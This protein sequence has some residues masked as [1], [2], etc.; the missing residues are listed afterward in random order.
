VPA[1]TLGTEARK[2]TCFA[3]FARFLCTMRLH[4][5]GVRQESRT[6]AAILLQRTP[7]SAPGGTN[8]D[9]RTPFA[10]LHIEAHIAGPYLWC[11][12]IAGHLPPAFRAD[13]CPNRW[14]RAEDV[15][16]TAERLGAGS[17]VGPCGRESQAQESNWALRMLVAVFTPC[18]RDT[19]SDERPGVSHQGPASTDISWI[20]QDLR[21]ER[22]RVQ[23]SSTA[24]TPLSNALGFVQLCPCQR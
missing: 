19:A 3:A 9:A 15:L 10:N 13:D 8:T 2:H 5:M 14:P 11:R 1:S 20:R 6:P 16:S 23:Q 22:P 4:A 24:T 21:A 7:T 12:L 17:E 18:C